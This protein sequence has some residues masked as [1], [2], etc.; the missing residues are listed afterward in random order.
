MA[1]GVQLILYLPRIEGGRELSISDREKKIERIFNEEL[2]CRCTMN[3]HP[4]QRNRQKHSQAGR[5]R[6]PIWRVEREPKNQSL[7][8]KILRKFIPTRFKWKELEYLPRARLSLSCN[9]SDFIGHPGCPNQNVYKTCF[10]TTSRNHWMQDVQHDRRN[11]PGYVLRV[12][13]NWRRSSKT[14]ERTIWI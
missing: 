6:N 14:S 9:G 1:C 11:N 12:F 3:V 7:A 8:Q 13:H 10:S 4:V 2:P 5:W